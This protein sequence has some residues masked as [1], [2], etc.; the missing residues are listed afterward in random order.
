MGID[1]PLPRNGRRA[2]RVLALQRG[3]GTSGLI[4]FLSPRTDSGPQR[5]NFLVNT[6]G[7]ICRERYQDG[8]GYLL[9][10]IRDAVVQDANDSEGTGVWANLEAM[11]AH[12]PTPLSTTG[13]C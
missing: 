12:V 5:D 8:N 6:S 3:I 13:I 1:E 9:H 10:D 4:P 7:P 2:D 11:K